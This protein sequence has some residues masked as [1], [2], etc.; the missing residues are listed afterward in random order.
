LA[1]GPW[2]DFGWLGLSLIVMG[3]SGVA[4]NSLIANVYGPAVLGVFN[5]LLAVLIVVGQIAT[6]GTQYSVLKLIA[7]RAD[8]P[9]PARRIFYSGLAVAAM[10]SAACAAALYFL[11]KPAGR[12]F[13]GDAVEQGLVWLAPAL[14]CYG[15]NKYLLNA[16][17]GLGQLKSYALLSALRFVLLGCAV[18][19]LALTDAPA[20]LLPAAFVVSELPLTVLLLWVCLGVFGPPRRPLSRVWMK[21]HLR[22]GLRA[23]PGGLVSEA[24]TRIDIVIASAFLSADRLG[25]YVFAAT[26]VEGAL[27]LPLIPRRIIEPRY[28]AAGSNPVAKFALLTEAR[29]SGLVLMLVGSMGCVVFLSTVLACGII[30]P[31]FSGAWPVLLVMLGGAIAY[32]SYAPLAGI[33]A[34]AGYPAQQSWLNMA[35]MTLNVL[36]NLALVPAFGIQGAAIAVSLSLV[37]SAV[38]LR[39]AVRHYTGHAV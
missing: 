3:G 35:S 10:A 31:E 5:V 24:N 26:L 11:S 7:E 21:Q 19:A 34:Q 39:A 37:F 30:G 28:A 8:R 25:V 32:G 23:M 1:A 4:V 17:N 20:S 12:V 13:G 33:L 6:V 9:R 27:Q 38:M 15:I 2:H 16:V 18:V 22:F 14:F 36:L 29:T